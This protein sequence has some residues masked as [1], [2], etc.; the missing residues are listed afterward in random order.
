M[1]WKTSQQSLY[2]LIKLDKS[3]GLSFIC[4]LSFIVALGNLNTILMSVLER[5]KEFGMMMAIGMKPLQL[6]VNVICEA[7]LMSF[8]GVV[9]GFIMGSITHIYF[10][11]IGIDI[12]GMIG[13]AEAG[14]SLFDPIMRSTLYPKDYFISA[15]SFIILTILASLYPALKIRKLNPIEVMTR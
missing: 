1:D 11:Y 13:S 4:I 6:I 9:F 12:S 5:R 7:T 8:V 3:S 2:S 10:L 14:N 15:I